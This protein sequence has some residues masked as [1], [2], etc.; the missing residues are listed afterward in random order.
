[1]IHSH[2]AKADVVAWL[3]HLRTGIPV[4][5][6]AYAWF[7]TRSAKRIYFYEWLDA[8]LLNRF[9]AVVAISRSLVEETVA[10]GV[11][12]NRLTIVRSGVDFH[13]LRCS[14]DRAAVRRQ[15]GLGDDD[16]VIGNLARLWPEKGQSVLL[17]SMKLVVDHSRSAK[18]L[19]IGDGPLEAE[20]KTQADSLGIGDN[21]VFAGFPANLPEILQVLDMQ[22]HSSHYEG[23]PMA[24]LQ[25]M[26]VGLPIV[27]TDVGGIHEVLTSG[28]N[29]ILVP[30]GEP[31]LMAESVLRLMNDHALSVRLGQSAQAFVE[32]NYSMEATMEQLAALYQRVCA[33]SRPKSTPE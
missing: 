17:E 30:P 22:V 3:A 10:R 1:V 15:L 4:V 16:F 23:I 6:S 7:G 33:A 31:R 2:D 5:G 12:R 19:I 20:L 18:L 32:A 14:P 29:A 11:D 26:V 9:A 25:G 24:I 21:V 28:E 27:A 13:R 8:H